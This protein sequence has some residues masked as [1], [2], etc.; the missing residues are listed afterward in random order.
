MFKV[1]HLNNNAGLEMVFIGTA[2]AFKNIRSLFFDGYL[3]IS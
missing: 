1:S 3:I 2:V